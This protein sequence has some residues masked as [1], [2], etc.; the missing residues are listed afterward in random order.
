MD[1]DEDTGIKIV[2]VGDGAIGKT[3]LL[4]SYRSNEFPTQHVPTIFENETIIREIDINGTQCEL[5]LDLW[6]TAGQEQFDRLRILAYKNVHVFLLCFSTVSKTS[7]SNLEAKW[8]PEIK[9][10]A[11]DALIVLVG[12]KSDLKDDSDEVVPD[13]E[14]QAYKKKCGAVEYIE[15]SALNR[16]NV[17]L[18]F[19]TAIRKFLE[20][21]QTEKKSSGCS[22]ILL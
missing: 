6:D 2:T 14:I 1:D 12:T 8:I 13:E 16:T 11:P 18:C 21:G 19:E 5:S 4:V 10:H 17:D 3:C 7:F 15:T 20:L 9:H 22:C